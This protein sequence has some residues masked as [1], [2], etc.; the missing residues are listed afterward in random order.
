VQGFIN[1]D[2]PFG[3]TSHDCV[4]RLRK[5]LRLRKVGHGGTL[6]PAATGVLP[7]AVGK[8][9][10]LL[11]FLPNDKAYEA[12]I[13]LGLQTTTDDLEGEVVAT[14]PVQGLTLAQV[15]PYLAQFHGVIDQI[16]PSYSAI[17]IGGKRLYDLARAGEAVTAPMRTVRV[18]AIKVLDWQSSGDFA[19][20]KVAIACGG[21]TYIRS[22]ARD[23]GAAIGTGGTLAAL[24]R[25]RSSGFSEPDSMTLDVLAEQIEAEAFQP[26]PPEVALHH[27]PS[28][29]LSDPQAQR[30]CYGQRLDWHEVTA[31]NAATEIS[32]SQSAMTAP[33]FYRIH[34][35]DDR[36][37]GIGT[38][39]IRDAEER[40]L[41]QLVWEGGE[42]KG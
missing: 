12:T 26:V 5:L 24:R 2:K 35:Q 4:A 11:Q 7:I 25:T 27:L 40:L 21:G 39:G 28:I 31:D 32:A 30:W 17:Q 38:H 22:I 6:D 19:D 29:V 9:T 36:F 16:P 1:L 20:L 37:L 3:L 41:P 13:R 14:Q 34:R 23:L 8:A 42:G 10:R 18:D 15:Q 33:T